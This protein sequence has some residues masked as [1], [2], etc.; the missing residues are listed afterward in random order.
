MY[1]PTQNHPAPRSGRQASWPI[2]LLAIGA[3]ALASLLGP[4]QQAFAQ[5]PQRFPAP[6]LAGGVAWLNTASPIRLKDLRGKIVL[7]DF[8]TLCCINCIH[9][10]PDLAKLEK[11]YP[12]ELVVIGV[13]SPKFENEKNTESIRKAILRYESSIPSSTTPT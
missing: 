3:F 2:L 6:E 10:L 1:L 7:L 5:G 8:W 9:T 12:N 4:L 11:K 13:H